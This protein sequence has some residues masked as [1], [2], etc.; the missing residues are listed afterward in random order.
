MHVHA[1]FLFK[2]TTNLGDFSK[3][4]WDLN[5]I[6]IGFLENLNGPW[7]FYKLADI[8]ILSLKS[9]FDDMCSQLKFSIFFINS[10]L[11]SEIIF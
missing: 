3:D 7:D 2:L 1:S 4:F 6:V 11:G 10:G 5:V 8:E 9:Q